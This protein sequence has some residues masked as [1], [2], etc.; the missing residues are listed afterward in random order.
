[1]N[2]RQ[3]VTTC[4][5]GLGALAVGKGAGA[6]SREV[7]PFWLVG[8]I[9][10]EHPWDGVVIEHGGVTG[11][12]DA[13]LRTR[14]DPD[15]PFAGLP[16]LTAPVVLSADGVRARV[17]VYTPADAAGAR[18][19]ARTGERVTVGAAFIATKPDG[20]PSWPDFREGA[21]TQAEV[22]FLALNAGPDDARRGVTYLVAVRAT[23]PAAALEAARDRLP[24]FVMRRTEGAGHV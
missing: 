6:A 1:M 14:M 7:S 23:T 18:E 19:M 2:R 4:A 22:T 12:D 11:W 17:G 20:A 9:D 8:V 13:P 24:R 16:R 10:T 15:A 3:F 21:V 5:A